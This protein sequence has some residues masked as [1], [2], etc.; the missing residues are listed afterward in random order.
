MTKHDRSRNPTLRVRRQ[1]RRDAI[2]RKLAFL[3]S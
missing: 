1:D 3:E 2:R